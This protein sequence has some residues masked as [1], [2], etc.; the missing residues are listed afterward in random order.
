MSLPVPPEFPLTTLMKNVPWIYPLVETF[1]IW[2]LVLLA[3]SA[4]LF[5]LRALDL[6]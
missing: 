1:H 6:G 5:D 3:R 4:I 2:G